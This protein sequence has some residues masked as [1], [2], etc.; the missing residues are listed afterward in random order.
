M[1]ANTEAMTMRECI[2]TLLAR[3]DAEQIKLQ[4][5]FFDL[6]T[7]EISLDAVLNEIRNQGYVYDN[8]LFRLAEDGIY[9]IG[10]SKPFYRLVF[11][12]SRARHAAE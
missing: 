9:R 5:D 3:E 11:G 8:M 10:A 1:T 7:I 12:D 4:Y 2:E 6:D